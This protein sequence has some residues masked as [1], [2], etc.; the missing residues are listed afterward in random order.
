MIE[1]ISLILNVVL[2]L[3]IVICIII[4]VG[5]LRFCKSLILKIEL[6][7]T[8]INA[9]STEHDRERSINKGC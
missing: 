2:V 3:L 1:V 4:L 9:R 5:I 6:L 8:I 7:E